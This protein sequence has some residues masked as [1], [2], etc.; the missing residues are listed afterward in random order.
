MIVQNKEEKV[1]FEF[2]KLPVVMLRDKT[3]YHLIKRKEIR[4][5]INCRSKGY[6][7]NRRFYTLSKLNS[8]CIKSEKIIFKKEVI[9]CPF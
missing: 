1:L 3:I 2:K 7:I 8:L 9:V 5:R 6:W 4:Q